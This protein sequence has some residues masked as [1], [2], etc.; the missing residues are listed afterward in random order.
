MTVKELERRVDRIRGSALV[1]LCRLPD[2]TEKE[3]SA[4]EF[5]ESGGDF[6]RVI[7]GND[8]H[9][10]DIILDTFKSAIE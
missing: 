1:V 4:E 9:D 8:L 6:I 3:M 5:A 10:V 7:R 2:G